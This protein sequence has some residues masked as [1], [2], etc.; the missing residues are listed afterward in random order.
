[1]KPR[2]W[3]QS[4]TCAVCQAVFEAHCTRPHQR[5]CGHACANRARAKQFATDHWR[6]MRAKSLETRK[7]NFDGRIQR[8]I[9]RMRQD[10]LSDVAIAKLFIRRGYSLGY[11]SGRYKARLGA[12]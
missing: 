4:R 9:D 7:R 12:V 8:T 1:M 3:P 2:K 10:G 11:Q 6:A 5:Y